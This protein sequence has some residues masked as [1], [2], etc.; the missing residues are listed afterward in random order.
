MPL[1]KREPLTQP[2]EQLLIKVIADQCHQNN[3][4]NKEKEQIDDYRKSISDP[5][6][7]EVIDCFSYE[8]MIG[9]LAVKAYNNRTMSTDQEIRIMKAAD[10][11]EMLSEEDK[12]D[13]LSIAEIA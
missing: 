5:L 1:K 10:V 11:I 7:K 2:I 8:Q 9:Y 6:K 13:I 12:E 3:I 4:S